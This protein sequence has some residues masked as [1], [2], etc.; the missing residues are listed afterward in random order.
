MTKRRNPLGNVAILG[1]G[2]VHMR[3]KSVIR[4]AEKCALVDDID[5]WYEEDDR[6]PSNRLD[7]PQAIEPSLKPGVIIPGVRALIT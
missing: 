5:A 4:A 7:G 1:K 6:Q 2:G 3:T